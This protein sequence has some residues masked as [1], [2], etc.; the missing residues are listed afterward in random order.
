MIN[1]DDWD[2][3][4]PLAFYSLADLLPKIRGARQAFSKSGLRLPRKKKK[5]K[6]GRNPGAFP[7]YIFIFPRVSPRFTQL[8]LK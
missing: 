7:L 5:G 4:R 8:R 1:D 3:V 2:K 6:R